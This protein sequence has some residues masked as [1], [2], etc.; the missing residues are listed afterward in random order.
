VL[1]AYSQ[2]DAEAGEAPNSET[3]WRA[4]LSADPEFQESL[5]RD[6]EFDLINHVT[7][8]MEKGKLDQF[9]ERVGRGELSG[10]EGSFVRFVWNYGA[11][12][13]QRKKRQECSYS[14]L[15]SRLINIEHRTSENALQNYVCYAYGATRRMSSTRMADPQ[16]TG[17]VSSLFSEDAS[18][19]NAEEW[20]LQADYAALVDSP[21]RAYAERRRDTVK[22]VLIELL[23]DVSDIRFSRPT[24]GKWS[25]RVEVQTPY[26]WVHLQSLSLGYRT[27]IAWVVDLAYRMFERHPGS[28]NPLAEP[29][30]VLVDE[31]DLHL[32]PKWQRS[33]VSYLTKRFPNTQFVVTAHSPL[34][35]QAALEANIVLLRREGD[36]VV[37]ENETTAIRNWRV[38]Q[39]LTSDLFGLASARPPRVERLLTKRTTLLSKSHLSRADQDRLRALDAQIGDLPV[40]ETPDD[41]EAMDIIREAA[42]AIR[43][44]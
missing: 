3:R 11:T 40:G 9:F 25:P 14:T 27:L 29:A 17:A 37:I 26:N 2:Q 1:Q 44:P 8:T 16:E 28:E 22:D 13:T 32:H 23:P 31:I 18:L 35:V 5:L 19:V 24:G 10:E 36:H 7:S 42:A 41:I 43:G 21:D 15:F 12:L 6:R 30:V 4:A 33:L 20:L 39:I 34:V 38:D